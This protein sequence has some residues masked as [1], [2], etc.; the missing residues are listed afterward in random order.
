MKISIITVC[1]NSEKFI[2]SAIH[3][4]LY[5]S[6]N[7]I[8]Y[9]VIDGGSMDKTLN[10]INSYGDGISTLVSEPDNGI[11][12]AMNKGLFRATG[13]IVGILNSDD[14]YL[15]DHV[16]SEVASLFDVDPQLDVVIGDV[17]F[18]NG[19]DLSLPVRRYAAGIFKP[20]MFRFGLMP[21]HPAVFVRKSAY[22][23]V[24]FYKL[25]YKIAADFD[26]LIRLMSVDGAKYQLAHRS[27]VRMRTGGASTNGLKS[28]ITITREMKRSLQEN[29]LYT[30]HLMLM[31]RLPFKLLTQ[32]LLK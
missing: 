28:L 15:H 7:D 24:G 22:S 3:S 11:Y 29:N 26:F 23:R 12:D 2:Q 31:C 27:W 25:S 4:V 32:V 14:F 30:N 19:N 16:L 17:D 5:Q 1:Y 21:P 6:H 18:V 8:E 10:I 9:I 13:E 20:W